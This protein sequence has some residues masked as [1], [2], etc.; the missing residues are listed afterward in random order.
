MPKDDRITIVCDSNYK[1]AAAEYAE[2][3]GRSLSDYARRALTAQMRR[4]R[5]KKL[6]KD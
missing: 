3:E 5:D 2:A 1:E 6:K 4:D